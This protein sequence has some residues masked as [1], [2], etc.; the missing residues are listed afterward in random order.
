MRFHAI[1]PRNPNGGEIMR[2]REAYGTKGE[3]WEIRCNVTKRGYQAVALDLRR[4]LLGRYLPEY[5]KQLQNLSDWNAA[6]NRR[7]VLAQEMAA[8]MNVT[9]GR[10]RDNRSNPPSMHIPYDVYP[11]LRDYSVV[12]HSDDY[13]TLSATVTDPQLLASIWATIQY[14]IDEKQEQ[15]AKTGTD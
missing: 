4:R 9:L 14:Y 15:K 12:V 11:G 13:M 6:Y 5:E 1:W 3:T 7:D 8:Q 2:P 10:D